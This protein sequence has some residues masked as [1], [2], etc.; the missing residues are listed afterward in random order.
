[1]F[2]LPTIPTGDKLKKYCSGF[3]NIGACW[4]RHRHCFRANDDE[5]KELRKNYSPVPINHY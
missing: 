5:S 3:E 2:V 1:M 4:F